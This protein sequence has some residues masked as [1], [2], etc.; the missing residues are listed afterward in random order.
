[1]PFIHN[2][3]SIQ[4]PQSS[5]INTLDTGAIQQRMGNRDDG[6]I[7][8]VS[9]YFCEGGGLSNPIPG[10]VSCDLFSANENRP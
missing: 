5:I 6:I 8:S 1:M 9:C 3:I 2:H 10:I 7:K 4:I